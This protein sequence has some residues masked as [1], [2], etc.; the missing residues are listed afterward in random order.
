MKR[1]RSLALAGATIAAGL[2][3]I[4]AAAVTAPAALAHGTMSDPG[5]RIW[6]CFYGDRTSPMCENA[7]ETNAQALYDWNEINQGAVAGAHRSLIPDGQ[8]CSAGR[9]K[10][11]AFDIPS[12]DWKATNLTPDADG[13]Y[14]L[15]WTSSAPHA[16]EYFRVYLTDENFDAT[17]PL[18]WDDLDL[19]FDSGPKGREATTTMR[20]ALPERDGR[21]ILY[22]VWQRSDSPEAF[23][24]CSDV[25]ID[26]D[27]AAQP[28][29]LPE[30]QPEPAPVPAPAPEPEPA[31]MPMPGHGDGHGSGHGDGHGHGGMT[32]GVMAMTTITSDWGSGYC[33]TVDVT[34]QSSTDKHWRI[35]LPEGIEVSS[36]WNGTVKTQPDGSVSV[37]GAAWNHMVTANSPTSFGYCATRTAPAPAPT[38]APAPA[39]T[40]APAPAPAPSGDLDVRLITDS[41]WGTGACYTLAVTN[42]SDSAVST[43]GARITLP[44]SV[45][46]SSSWSGTTDVDGRSVSVTAPSWGGSIPAGGTVTHFGFCTIGSGTPTVTPLV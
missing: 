32:E 16:T 27:G 33:A 4:T 11:A 45:T 17:Q 3:G 10:Y 41:N 26:S 15:T 35:D 31:P 39:P 38:P 25:T 21:H 23:Y 1:T 37:E 30:P 20:M 24:A 28:A 40:P 34:T 13:L 44:V 43:W 14:T 12:L 36:L 6:E 18:A 46:M 19:V 5:S 7:W 9:S 8:L 42:N 22:T 29:P 2:T